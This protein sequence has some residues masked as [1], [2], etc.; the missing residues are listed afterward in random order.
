MSINASYP[1]FPHHEHRKLKTALKD[2]AKAGAAS[3]RARID[4]ANTAS[5]FGRKLTNAITAPFSAIHG[6][7]DALVPVVTIMPT[8][9]TIVQPVQEPLCAI[10]PAITSITLTENQVQ[11]PYLTLA[12]R[13]AA[14]SSDT[15]DINQ[16]LDEWVRADRITEAQ[17]STAIPPRPKI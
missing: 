1:D 9:I 12:E 16:I 8:E 5:H 17:Q 3:F 13:K 11:A 10:T 6:A 14:H 2:A 7:F 15:I 4:T